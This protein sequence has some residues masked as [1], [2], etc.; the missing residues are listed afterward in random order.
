MYATRAMAWTP[1]SNF[2]NFLTSNDAVDGSDDACHRHAEVSGMLPSP[3]F[4]ISITVIT[5]LLLIIG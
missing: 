5:K 1:A 3:R 2:D 4:D